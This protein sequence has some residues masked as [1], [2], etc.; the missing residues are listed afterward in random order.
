MKR[1][2]IKTPKKPRTVK[3]LIQSYR[4]QKEI[5]HYQRKTT[6]VPGPWTTIAADF[7]VDPVLVPSKSLYGALNEFTGI[8]RTAA[9]W[10]EK[11]WYPIVINITFPNIKETVEQHGLDKTLA[12]TEL[13]LSNAKDQHNKSKYGDV[14]L[15]Y[16]FVDHSQDPDPNHRFLSCYAKTNKKSIIG[17]MATRK[18]EVIIIKEK[19]QEEEEQEQS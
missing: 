5:T 10:K 18:N 19:T 11:G 1:K 17:F 6:I 16:V 7:T 13:A 3:Q 2:K 15:L 12:A 4:E 14:V 9:D 8:Y